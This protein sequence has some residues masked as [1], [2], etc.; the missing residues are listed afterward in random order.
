MPDI[1][2]T[3]IILED[4]YFTAIDLR[5][6]VKRLRPGYRLAAIAETAGEAIA[7]ILRDAP[8]LLIADTSASDGDSINLLLKA[9]IDTPVI[10]ISEYA[11]L[12]ERARSLNMAGF[13]LKPVTSPDMQRALN[14]F[15]AMRENNKRQQPI[16]TTT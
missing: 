1:T 14:A 16:I 12:A 4:A 15:D 10:F 13:I 2:L 6:T 11:R 5:E 7:L 8:D 9:G 3:Y